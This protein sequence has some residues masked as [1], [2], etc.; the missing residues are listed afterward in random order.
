MWRRIWL[1]IYQVHDNH[2]PYHIERLTQLYLGA[3]MAVSGMINKP[4][5]SYGRYKTEKG[6]L[7]LLGCALASQGISRLRLFE[8]LSIESLKAVIQL[9]ESYKHEVAA[10]GEVGL[11]ETTEHDEQAILEHY[12]PLADPLA[13]RLIHLDA[14]LD[15]LV[16]DLEDEHMEIYGDSIERNG[17]LVKDK[18]FPNR[19]LVA[20]KQSQ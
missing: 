4:G 1:G 18:V 9:L 10:L 16:A 5:D 7:G 2:G 11:R 8:G 15:V 6:P 17:W 13:R 14:R 12:P 3:G 20:M 19:N